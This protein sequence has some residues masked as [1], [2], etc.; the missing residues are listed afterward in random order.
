MK[1]V[2]KKEKNCQM[3]KPELSTLLAMIGNLRM[4]LDK[5]DPESEIEVTKTC[6]LGIYKELKK[7]SFSDDD[8]ARLMMYREYRG[9]KADAKTWQKWAN[10]DSVQ[11]EKIKKILLELYEQDSTPK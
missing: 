5:Y 3:L 9:Y 10:E 6:I 1:L 8:I 11:I 2:A 7:D 4:N